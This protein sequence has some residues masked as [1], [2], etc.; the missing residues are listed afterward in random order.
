MTALGHA[1]IYTYAL[2]GKTLRYPSLSQN[3]NN[4]KVKSAVGFSGDFCENKLFL[5]SWWALRAQSCAQTMLTT[6]RRTCYIAKLNSSRFATL[7][8]GAHALLIMLRVVK[9]SSIRRRYSSGVDADSTRCHSTPVS[10]S[11]RR[12]RSRYRKLFRTRRDLRTT[13]PSGPAPPAWYRNAIDGSEEFINRT[14]RLSTKT[15]RQIGVS[16]PQIGK[17]DRE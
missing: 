8:T 16:L 14:D 13:G 15:D 2:S 5:I 6:A 4:T 12:D 17:R 7:D 3:N 1:I 11:T 9:R 10:T